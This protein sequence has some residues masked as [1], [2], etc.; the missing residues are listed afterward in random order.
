[1]NTKRALSLF[2]IAVVAIVVSG[3]ISFE[4]GYHMFLANN[5]PQ[6]KPA[7]V[8]FEAGYGWNFTATPNGTVAVGGLIK[9]DT[10]FTIV[11]AYTSTE[12]VGVLI[13]NT[14]YAGSGG[15]VNFSNVTFAKS[16]TLSI[17]MQ[18]GSYFFFIVPEPS[19]TTYSGSVTITST[20]MFIPISS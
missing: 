6:E 14:T 13:E 19:N 10:N 7:N 8:I 18:P 16:Q 9:S 20:I 2:T 3:Y 11:G 15:A 4:V 17:A 1:M 5:H 12:P